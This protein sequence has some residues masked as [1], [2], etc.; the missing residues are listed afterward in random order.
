[1]LLIA[2][3]ELRRKRYTQSARER[4]RAASVLLEVVLALALFIGAATVISAGISASVD[5]VHRVRLQ[6]HAANLA[7]SIMSELKIGARPLAAVGPENLEVPFDAWLY[8]V[9][10][11]ASDTAV[12]ESDSTRTVEVIVWHTQENVVHRVTQLFRA[13]EFAA[14]QEVIP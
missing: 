9:N 12:S 8:R 7:I 14:T 6:T 5:A 10:L 2:P 13:S 1:M 3:T 4:V 11:N